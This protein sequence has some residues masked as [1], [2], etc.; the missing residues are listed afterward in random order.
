MLKIALAKS[1]RMEGHAGPFW[2]RGFFDHILRSQES[3]AQKWAY[4]QL[5]PIRAG[6]VSRVDE[7]PYQGE[8]FPLQF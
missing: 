3:Y 7:W 8:I 6:L 1:L 4:V 5:N 2:Q